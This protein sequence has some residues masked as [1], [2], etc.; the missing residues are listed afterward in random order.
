MVVNTETPRERSLY[1]PCPAEQTQRFWIKVN[2]A[3][4]TGEDAT[5]ALGSTHCL[6]PDWE[7]AGVGAW[8]W[9]SLVVMVVQ[10]QWQCRGVESKA[11]S[12]EQNVASATGLCSESNSPPNKG[13][14]RGNN[15]TAGKTAI[16][17]KR[18]KE[19]SGW[20][21][22]LRHQSQNG[23]D[24]PQ[25]RSPGPAATPDTIK[26]YRKSKS[27]MGC[28]P[29]NELIKILGEMCSSWHKVYLGC[30]FAWDLQ[31]FWCSRTLKF[32]VSTSSNLITGKPW[33]TKNIKNLDL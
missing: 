19:D 12:Q 16:Q 17:T 18:Q 11:T 9:W 13:K 26:Y 23:E 32:S 29:G 14:P 30:E 3:C 15:V 8:G 24:H 25:L 7:A 21:P 6:H 28:E 27:F 2:K 1:P 22:L 20:P 5:I 10:T 31:A 33:K 4:P